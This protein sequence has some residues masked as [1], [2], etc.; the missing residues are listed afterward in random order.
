M[1]VIQYYEESILHFYL[2]CI[3][4]IENE[5]FRTFL[6]KNEMSTLLS[7]LLH[8]GYSFLHQRILILCNHIAEKGIYHTMCRELINSYVLVV[9]EHFKWYL[10]MKILVLSEMVLQINR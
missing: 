7:T 9:N 3:K 5:Q 8:E 10:I 6:E 1:K 4:D 2:D